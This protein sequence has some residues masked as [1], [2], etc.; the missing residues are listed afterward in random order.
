MANLVIDLTEK[1]PKCNKCTFGKKIPGDAHYSC[2]KKTAIIEANLHGIKNGWVIYPFNF[3]PMWIEACDSYWD[4]EKEKMLREKFSKFSLLEWHSFL[5]NGSLFSFLGERAKRK[6]FESNRKD[7]ILED[8]ADRLKKI[9]DLYRKKD[10][11][12]LTNYCVELLKT[13]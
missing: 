1:K 5:E 3:D 6:A 12:A 4:E 2:K 11:T 10:L 7:L 13:Y 8:Y 9:L